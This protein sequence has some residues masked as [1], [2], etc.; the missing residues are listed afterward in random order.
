MSATRPSTATEWLAAARAAAEA[1]D[2]DRALRMLGSVRDRAYQ[3]EAQSLRRTWR[4]EAA[5][6]R[7]VKS[8]RR[9]LGL[10]SA[11]AAR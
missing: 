10:W 7:A 3:A 9:E 6:G 2:F 8:A 4:A 11:S 5:A 1:R